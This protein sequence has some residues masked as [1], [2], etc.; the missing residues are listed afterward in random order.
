MTSPASSPS[1]ST[2][3]VVGLTGGIGSGKTLVSTRLQALGAAIVDTDVIAHSLT[4]P[5]GAAMAAI[6]EQFGAEFMT[7]AGA[8][9][10]ARMRALVFATPAAKHRLEAILHPL[11]RV[12]TGAEARRAAA[13]APYVVLVIPLLVEAG[14]WKTGIDRVLLVDCSVD[15]QIERVQ[16]RSKLDRAAVRAI[17]A[18]QATRQER[19]DVA[20]DVVVN[21]AE[22]QSL[23]DRLSRLH[24]LYSRLAATRGP[25]SV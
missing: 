9:D 16:K 21:Q 20:D 24:G 10:R 12:A 22:P 11:I 14:N 15:T 13:R 5:K 23:A 19:L 7:S 8:L 3:L 6:A 1:N 4:A 17:V 25:R 2:G 18:Q